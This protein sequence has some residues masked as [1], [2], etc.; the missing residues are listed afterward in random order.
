MIRTSNV[1]FSYPDGTTFQFPDIECNSS[2][3]LLILGKSGIGK[4]T[5]LHILGGILKPDSN[6]KVLIDEQDITKLTKNQLDFFRGRNIGIVFQK[7]QFVQSISLL[8]NLQLFNYIANIKYDKSRTEEIL[9]RL[10]IPN[11]A[12]KRPGKL[13]V[14]EQQR[15]SIARAIINKPKL[16]LADEPTAALD[17][18]N[19]ENVIKLLQEQ[20]EIEKAALVIVTHDQRLTKYFTNH[21]NINDG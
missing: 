4:T 5:L 11:L 13:S 21:L 10:D 19:C 18:Q 2:D 20:A 15:A 7:S 9:E 17:D 14:G 1:Q 6:S 3:S 12:N 8:E 16:I